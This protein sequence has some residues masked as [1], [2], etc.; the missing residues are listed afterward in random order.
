MLSDRKPAYEW[1]NDKDRDGF[2]AYQVHHAGQWA[3]G[4]L[5]RAAVQV[6]DIVPG[7]QRTASAEMGVSWVRH[8]STWFRDKPITIYQT[9]SAGSQDLDRTIRFTAGDA[10]CVAWSEYRAGREPLSGKRLL[11]SRELRGYYCGA[12]GQKLTDAEVAAARTGYEVKG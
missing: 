5:P 8:L 6:R 1:F 11:P 4:G 7:R 12:E 2:P 3:K 10:D 9:A